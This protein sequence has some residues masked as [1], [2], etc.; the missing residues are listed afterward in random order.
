MATRTLNGSTSL[1]FLWENG[2]AV[3][4]D[5]HT[6][7]VKSGPGGHRYAVLMIRIDS[8]EPGDRITQPNRNT[9]TG[10]GNLGF[11]TAFSSVQKLDFG[12]ARGPISI[13]G[14]YA[15]SDSVPEDWKR[16]DED[17]ADDKWAHI[18]RGKSG[19][20]GASTDSSKLL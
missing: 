9:G 8:D 11:A 2:H 17:L 5:Y 13:S 4:D 15:I 14:K 1:E 16:F 20:K 10:G 19:G 18:R 7:R 3:S 6:A 12:D